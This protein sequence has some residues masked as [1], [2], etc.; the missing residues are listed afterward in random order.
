MDLRS[1]L[2]K[3]YIS[4]ALIAL[5]QVKEYNKISIQDIVDKAG[6]SR[7][8]YYRN[9]NNKDE[10]IIYY[11]EENTRDFFNR[12]NVNINQKE[13]KKYIEIL[14][15]DLLE[16]KKMLL[17]KTLIKA[18]LTHYIKNEI[19]RVLTSRTDNQY[20]MYKQLFIAGG[21]FNVYIEWVSNGCKET[22]EEMSNILNDFFESFILH[23]A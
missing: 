17:T 13:W 14:F 2:S 10:I 12:L 19:E 6:L 11:L 5:L 3:Q 7:I 4:E 21:I 1:T 15:R 22:P 8:T 9:F 18:D 23:Q 20:E 16:E